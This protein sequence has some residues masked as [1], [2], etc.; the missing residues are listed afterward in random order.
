MHYTYI[1]ISEDGKKIY[2][3]HTVDLQKRLQ[4]HNTGKVKSSKKYRPYEILKIGAFE[5]LKEAKERELY[6]KNYRGRQRIKKF[7]EEQ[8]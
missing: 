2:T 6:Y 8:V 5:T 7:I 1:L 4:E 3:G